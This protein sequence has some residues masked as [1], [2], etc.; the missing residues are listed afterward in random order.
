LI[1]DSMSWD[2]LVFRRHLMPSNYVIP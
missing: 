2:N 1:R